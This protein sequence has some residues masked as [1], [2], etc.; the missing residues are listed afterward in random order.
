[1]NTL[2]LD[3]RF[4]HLRRLLFG[5]IA[6]GGTLVYGASLAPLVDLSR[7]ALSLTVITGIS[8]IV[9]GLSMA[10]LSGL[11]LWRTADHCLGAM[12]IGE[13]V[14]L[15]AAGING[16]LGEWL[17]Q[18]ILVSLVNLGFVLTANVVMGW[19]LAESFFR[20]GLSRRRTWLCWLLILNG[21][22]L[23]ATLILNLYQP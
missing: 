7:F 1:M 23:G 13:L 4:P 11:S 21:V 14:L 18:H 2:L 5:S 8:W 20:D 6:V 17:A 3:Q 10:S 12:V 19:Y 16:L 15:T 9:F 22:A